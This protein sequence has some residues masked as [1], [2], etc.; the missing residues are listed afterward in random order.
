MKYLVSALIVFFM[1]TQTIYGQKNKLKLGFLGFPS[2]S[3]FGIGDIGYE[4]FKK[5]M[6]SSWQF[7]F[8]AS[9]GAIATD[10]G[11]ESRKWV[12]VEKTFYQKTIAKKITWSYSFFTEIGNRLKKPGKITYTPEKILQET[13]Y[14]EVSPGASL[15]IQIGIGKRWGVE[16]QVGPKLI[17]T[18]GK[19]YYRNSILNHK[20]S[21][22][23]GQVKAGF[24]IIG[25]FYYKF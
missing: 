12:T 4:K 1:I 8:S 19:E 5:D 11:T 23:A 16:S 22:S 18:K 14:F 7:H 21:V 15:G 13:K 10:I 2:Q 20:Y 9:G 6:T 17:F 3:G 24:R 25:E